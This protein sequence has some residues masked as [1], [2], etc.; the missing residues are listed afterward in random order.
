MQIY[1][2]WKWESSDRDLHNVQPGPANIQIQQLG[3][4][5]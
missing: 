1:N 3:N 5:Q 4:I 2:Y